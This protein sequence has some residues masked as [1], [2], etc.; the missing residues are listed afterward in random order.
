ML[1]PFVSRGGDTEEDLDQEAALKKM[2]MLRQ[3]ATCTYITLQITYVLRLLLSQP[4][5]MYVALTRGRPAVDRLAL[6]FGWPLCKLGEL[7]K[8]E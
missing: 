3:V 2:L 1:R 5:S 7:W 4:R 6:A 8:Q